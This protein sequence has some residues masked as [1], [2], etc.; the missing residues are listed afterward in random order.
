MFP[1]FERCPS[2]ETEANKGFSLTTSEQFSFYFKDVDA[3]KF[4]WATNPF[5]IY[6]VSGL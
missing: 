1:V 3:S 4:E 2:L 5:A 6:I